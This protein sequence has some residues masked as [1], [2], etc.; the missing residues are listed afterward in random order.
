MPNFIKSV[1]TYANST[2]VQAKMRKI[3]CEIL[4]NNGRSQ[5]DTIFEFGSYFDEFGKMIRQMVK[6]RHF[7][8]SDICDFGLKFDANI[9]HCIIDMNH[10]DYDIKADLIISNACLQ[11]L[12]GTEILS[13]I[14]QS[15]NPNGEIL[16]STFGERNFTQIRELTG[17]GLDYPSILDLQNALRNFKEINIS[18]EIIDLHFGYPIEL[19]AHI[20]HSGVGEMGRIFVGKEMLKKC[21]KIYANTLTYHPVYIYAKI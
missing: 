10:F 14:S 2:P 4:R 11:W 15:L 8:S 18:E 16:I 13:K 5:Y 6:F 1:S 12:N 21:E 20:K 9:T 17:V 7:I 3:L 19:F